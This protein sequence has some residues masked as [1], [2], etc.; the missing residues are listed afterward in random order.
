MEQSPDGHSHQFAEN[1]P[2]HS[3]SSNIEPYQSH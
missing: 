2:Q 1:R 3:S